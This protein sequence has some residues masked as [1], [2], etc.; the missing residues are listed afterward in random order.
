MKS[1]TLALLTLQLW[2][3]QLPSPARPMRLHQEIVQPLWQTPLETA[4]QQ[5]VLSAS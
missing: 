3:P 5:A 4:V 2:H 1:W